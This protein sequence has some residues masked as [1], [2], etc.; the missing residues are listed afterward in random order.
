ME[1]VK[2]QYIEGLTPKM[3]TI[4]LEHQLKLLREDARMWAGIY[5]DLMVSNLKLAG[6]HGDAE[7]VERINNALS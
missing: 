1:T 6:L 7:T 3:V 2:D 4:E 5:G